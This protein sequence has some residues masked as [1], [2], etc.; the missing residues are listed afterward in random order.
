MATTETLS[1][2]LRDAHAMESATVDNLDKQ[3]ERLEHYPE[4]QGRLRQHREESRRHAEQVKHCLERL[5]ADTSM[6]KDIG[7]RF[8]GKV[9]SYVAGATPDEVVKNCIASHA[10][11]HFEVA[12]YTSLIGAA[13]ACGQPEVKQVCEEIRREDE[14]MADWLAQNLPNITQQYLHREASEQPTAKA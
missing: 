14:A 2:W 12:S 8:M 4:L 3:V 9:Q 10:F 13:E 5:G 11:E 7:T 6:I 1:A